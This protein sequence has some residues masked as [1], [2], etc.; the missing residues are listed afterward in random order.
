MKIRCEVT[1]LRLRLCQG[2]EVL[3]NAK[4]KCF[5]EMFV[6]RTAADPTNCRRALAL[7][8]SA[9]TAR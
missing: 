9:S 7:F 3:R 6:L 8:H 4:E 1:S 5:G 2:L